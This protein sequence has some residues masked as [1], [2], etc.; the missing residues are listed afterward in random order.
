VNAETD[1]DP[2]VKTELKIL[3]NYQNKYGSFDTLYHK[4]KTNFEKV[5]NGF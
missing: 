4:K 1:P 2:D 3:K 5:K